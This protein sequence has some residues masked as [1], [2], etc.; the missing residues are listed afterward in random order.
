MPLYYFNL[1]DGSAGVID[2]EGTIL[3][4]DAAARAYALRVAHELMA[5]AEAK[6]RHWQLDVSDDSGEV[7]FH[8]PFVAAD[9]TIHG[10][11]ATT[12][13]LVERLCQE[14]RE[15]AEAVFE[16]RLM[17]LRSRAVRARSRGKP[18]LVA[19]FGRRV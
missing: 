15:L 18:Y 13:R 16:A 3:P 8:L 17:I 5:H 6:R 14:Q 9:D 19:E 11:P 10:L 1:R 2:P 12:R 4:D 7:L